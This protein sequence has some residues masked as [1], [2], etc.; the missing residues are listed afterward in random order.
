MVMVTGCA[1]PAFASDVSLCEMVWAFVGC[2]LDGIGEA[3][4]DFT[5]AKTGQ[6]LAVITSLTR[7]VFIEPPPR[8]LGNP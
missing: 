8:W 4:R 2:C 5:V 1:V 3:F 7:H 6:K